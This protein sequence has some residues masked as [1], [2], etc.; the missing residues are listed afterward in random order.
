LDA[1]LLNPDPGPGRY[2]SESK[3]GLWPNPDS[4][5][6]HGVFM[7]KFLKIYNWKLV[8]IKKKNVIYVQ[9]K[10]R[11]FK[12]EISSFFRFWGPISAGMDPLI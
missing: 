7:T 9:R 1:D 5:S 10:F 8:F 4:D 12:V 2:C 3:V 6:D 11:L